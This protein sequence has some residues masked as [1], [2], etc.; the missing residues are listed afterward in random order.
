MY[1]IFV[2]LGHAG[3]GRRG[4]GRGTGD[5]LRCTETRILHTDTCCVVMT[6]IIVMHITTTKRAPP[7]A[8]R[9][10]LP[11]RPCQLT[12]HHATADAS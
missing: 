12:H 10:S 1:I 3:G 4:A 7:S 5:T 9:I 2:F 8:R 6:V 11:P